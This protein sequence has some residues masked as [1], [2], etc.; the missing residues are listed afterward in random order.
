[1]L[2]RNLLGQQFGR[3]KVLSRAS[4]DRQGKA[5]WACQCDCGVQKIVDR[6]SLLGGSTKSC[7]CLRRSSDN[8]TGRQFGRLKVLSQAGNDKHQKTRWTCL[9]DCGAH[10]IVGRR[11]LLNGTARSCGCLRREVVRDLM[12]THRMTGTGEYRSYQGAKGR[13]ENPNNAAFANYGGRGIQF[14]YVSFEQFFEDMGPR[15]RGMSLERCDNDGHYEPGNC[16]WAPA[17]EQANNKRNN[18]RLTA[19]GRTRTLARWANEVGIFRNVLEW[20]LKNGWSAEDV[21]TRP[22]RR[23]RRRAKGTTLAADEGAA[24]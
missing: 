14:L 12:S 6:S 22:I 19:F 23:D 10:T 5:R 8:L 7:G 3:L 4:N 11:N 1:M 21:L 15:P 13:C 18:I 9:C 20:R 2:L 16:R 17:T 24:P